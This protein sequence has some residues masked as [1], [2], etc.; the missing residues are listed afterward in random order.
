MSCIKDEL[1]KM[2]VDPSVPEDSLAQALMVLK[3]KTLSSDFQADQFLSD[4]EACHYC[5]GIAHS[6]LWAWRKNGLVS[7]QVGGRRLYRKRNLDNYILGNGLRKKAGG[8][9]E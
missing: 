5:G 7:H 2:A 6:T 8:G 9:N 3:G 1:I 4:E